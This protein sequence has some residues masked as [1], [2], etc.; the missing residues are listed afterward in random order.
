[1]S[2]K[3]GND[4]SN[5]E[6]NHP[7]RVVPTSSKTFKAPVSINSIG[8]FEQADSDKS[9]LISTLFSLQEKLNS[10]DD[11]ILKQYTSFTDN[12]KKRFVSLCLDTYYFLSND[13][14]IN[15]L[16]ITHFNYFCLMQKNYQL[17]K[18]NFHVIFSYI[19]HNDK[20]QSY[21][22]MFSQQNIFY[23]VSPER[24]NFPKI[25]NMQP[26]PEKTLWRMVK[27]SN[28]QSFYTCIVFSLIEKWIENNNADDLFTFFLDTF[29]FKTIYPNAFNLFDFHHYSIMLNLIY[30]AFALGQYDDIKEIFITYYNNCNEIESILTTY[31]KYCIYF[32]LKYIY[33]NNTNEQEE[34]KKELNFFD[35]EEIISP[36]HETSRIII[37]LIS[38]IY[39]VNIDIYYPNKKAQRFDNVNFTPEKK[40][41]NNNL[42][43][44]L[45]YLY[46][47]YH[48]Y[49]TEKN[50][51]LTKSESDKKTDSNCLL[52]QLSETGL[53]LECNKCKK[54]TK[55]IKYNHQGKEIFYCY[56]CLNDHINSI[57]NERTIIFSD[58]LFLYKELYVR[59]I[60]LS[61]DVSI[62]DIEILNCFQVSLHDLLVRNLLLYCNVCGQKM[63]KDEMVA[64]EC[65]CLYCSNCLND[66][67]DENFEKTLEKKLNQDMED[68]FILNCKKCNKD[69][70]MKEVLNIFQSTSDLFNNI[71]KKYFSSHC[72]LC[73]KSNNLDHAGLIFEPLAVK[74]ELMTSI[75]PEQGTINHNLCWSCYKNI[76]KENKQKE[77]NK[78]KNKEKDTPHAIHICLICRKPHKTLSENLLIDDIQK[79][80]TNIEQDIEEK[81]NETNTESVTNK[82]ENSKHF[83]EKE[84]REKNKKKTSVCSCIIM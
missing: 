20:L 29:R 62:N 71:R 28:Y 69:I 34:D 81:D 84:L 60:N 58:N 49:Y 52:F 23:K 80:E 43:I 82:S 13:I 40:V 14:S 45:I 3:D 54:K 55:Y 24:G 77:K 59:P 63:P 66:F 42:K 5:Q 73:G 78:S 17:Y 61:N 39:N 7:F 70:N 35:L 37:E 16:P 6:K 53:F 25:P 79:K 10:Y 30:D 50:Y 18:T 48:L 38:N 19:F 76:D 51:K 1:M 15:N 46:A 2:D 68:K 31:V 9:E 32:Y 64:L 33:S 74:E 44:E 36:Y 4:K 75:T 72:C 11:E 47:S 12:K 41:N 83:T 56:D 8:I 67:L 65:S 57:M 26:V 22:Q 27:S 21:N